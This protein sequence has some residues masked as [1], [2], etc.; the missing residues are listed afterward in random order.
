M[1]GALLLV[2]RP[3]GLYLGGADLLDAH[4]LAP[5][6]AAQRVQHAAHGG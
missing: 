6:P 1:L 4:F 2:D 5:V 3:H